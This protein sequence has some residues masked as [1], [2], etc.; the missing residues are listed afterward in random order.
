MSDQGFS[1]WLEHLWL[2]LSQTPGCEPGVDKWIKL[3]SFVHLTCRWTWAQSWR[4]ATC[5]QRRQTGESSSTCWPRCW[6]STQIKGSRPLRRSTIHLLLWLTCWTSPI[7]HS[8]PQTAAEH[9]PYTQYSLFLLLCTMCLTFLIMRLKWQWLWLGYDCM[10]TWY[11]EYQTAW[12][13]WS[14]T[15]SRRT[16]AW[17]C[18]REKVIPNWVVWFTGSIFAVLWSC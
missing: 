17:I 2:S 4:A 1:V 12:V 13:R 10:M 15:S 6:P 3:S 5:W 16:L 11:L 8:E 14:R 18:S 7:A 9:K